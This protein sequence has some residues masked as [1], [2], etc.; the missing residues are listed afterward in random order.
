MK[1][2][3]ICILI[4]FLV[5]ESGFSQTI[6]LQP[7]EEEIQKTTA[8]GNVVA[9]KLLSNLQ[10]ELL[11][12][13]RK[14]NPVDAIK[15]CNV[16]ALPLTHSLLTSEQ[17]IVSIKRTTEKYRNELNRPDSIEQKAIEYFKANWENDPDVFVQKFENSEGTFTRYYRAMKVKGLCL[18]CHGTDKKMNP[19]IK[20]ELDKLYPK[21]K[22]RGYKVGDFRGA[23]SITFAQN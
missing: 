8:V 17:N 9:K 18:K 6:L 10:A 3:Q 1:Q 13:M 15:L 16:K 22:A 21:D 2:L 23:I 4:L 20:S 14:G 5:F 12:E 7:S 11:K 19:E